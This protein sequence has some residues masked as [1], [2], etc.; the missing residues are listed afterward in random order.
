MTTLVFDGIHAEFLTDDTPEIDLEGGRSS[1]KTWAC[2][3]K[4]IQSCLAHPG[5]EWLICR[6]SGEETKTKL[7]PE[8]EKLCRLYFGLEPAWSEKEK[9]YTFDNGSKV[10]AYGLKTQDRLAF[11]AKIRGLGVAAV[12]NDQ[13]EELPEAIATELRTVVRQQG[14][15]HQ[16]IFS[17]NPC[18]ED[19]WL[20][21]QFPEDNSLPGRRHYRLSLY[22]NKKNI[23]EKTITGIE[24]AYPPTHAKHKSLILGRRGVNVVGTPVY[25]DAFLRE[26]HV[27]PVVYDPES[28]LLEAIDAGKHNPTWI[29]AQRAGTGGLHLL[30]GLMGKRLFLE[31]FLPIV[32]RYRA[33]W[34]D[35]PVG[36]GRR[37]SLCCDPPPSDESQRL[38]YTNLA[39]LRAAGL[40]PRYVD[41][42]M[43]PDVREAVIQNLAG[44]MKRRVGLGSAFVVN[45]DQA[46]WLMCSQTVIKRSPFFVDGLEGAY[47]WD[48]HFVSV[49]NKKVR[50]PK[51]DEWVDGAQRCLENLELNFN[52]RPRE[53]ADA[54]AKQIHADLLTPSRAGWSG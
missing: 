51:V 26:L 8:F 48:E 40:K 45:S 52:V 43:A 34:F 35:D 4:V 27:A 17:P 22:D 5:I 23:P 39:I 20:A 29:A 32:D 38:R 53:A 46:R 37:M 47:V 1:G 30:G 18:G 50:Q 12:W 15:P 14:F 13:T 33:E 24:Q 49:G 44:R 9:S 3:A 6:Y 21:D 11:F 16:I 7:Q 25:E 2:C 31:D 36:N 28:T 19:H 54:Q 10:F 41:N 42:A